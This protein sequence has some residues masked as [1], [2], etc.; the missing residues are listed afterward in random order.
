MS[1]RFKWPQIASVTWYVLGATAASGR[2]R[3]S[4]RPGQRAIFFQ[5]TERALACTEETCP[6]LV[7]QRT[8]YHSYIVGCE[9]SQVDAQAAK[10][11]RTGERGQVSKR[12]AT[13]RVSVT[14][15]RSDVS[16]LVTCPVG[17]A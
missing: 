13:K 17:H 8:F 6:L 12:A 4:S 16:L 7:M 10:R 1:Q 15:R 2:A 11:T 5:Q 3:S 14:A 9:V